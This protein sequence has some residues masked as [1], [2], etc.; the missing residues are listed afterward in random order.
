MQITYVEMIYEVVDNKST[1]I[2]KIQTN[3]GDVYY[4][5]AGLLATENWM[6]RF[7]AK[8]EFDRSTGLVYNFKDFD[9]YPQHVIDKT[10]ADNVALIAEW[11][12]LLEAMGDEQIAISNGGEVKAGEMRSDNWK[13]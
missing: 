8:D 6:N 1:L 9:Y 10:L 3:N 4:Q 11:T 12:T 7:V 13:G 2:A 5:Y